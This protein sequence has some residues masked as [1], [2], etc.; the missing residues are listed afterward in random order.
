MGAERKV[1]RGWGAV[2][3]PGR[4]V[5]DTLH[6]PCGRSLRLRLNTLQAPP[7]A[8]HR[9]A[10]TR[11]LVRL[12]V[13]SASHMRP[14]KMQGR[15]TGI[16]SQAEVRSGMVY[17]NPF[18]RL[19]GSGTLYSGQEQFS[20][21]LSL[22]RNI[23]GQNAPTSVPAGVITAFTDL[24]AT[25]TLI[26]TATK[27][28]TI[29]LN[30]IGT[31][32]KYLADTTVY[33]DFLT[34]LPGTVATNVPPQIALAISLVTAR[35]RGRAHAGRFYLPCPGIGVSAVTG[36]LSVADQNKYRDACVTF[37]N[38]INLS[39]PGFQVGVTS[40]LGTGREEEV[41]AVRV[42]QAM[43]TIRSRR[44]KMPENYSQA[45]LTVV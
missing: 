1:P 24:W 43:D 33:H 23:P 32:G 44:S 19:V 37:L 26:T 34:P 27:L 35:A 8:G 38:K 36:V 40:D 31:N 13:V 4:R 17:A 3:A 22:I 45:N 20:F 2:G 15:P 7:G 29:K 10:L 14:D 41:T 42:G 5:F 18:L 12:Q 11:T 30:E 16:S 25:N 6:N 21:G 9:S 28:S 39:V